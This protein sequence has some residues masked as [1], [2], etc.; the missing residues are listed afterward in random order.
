MNGILDW[1]SRDFIP[2]VLSILKL[3]A[4]L[5]RAK[6]P[7]AASGFHRYGEKKPSDP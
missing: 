6:A 1:L 4:A 3:S 7:L 2:V 5:G